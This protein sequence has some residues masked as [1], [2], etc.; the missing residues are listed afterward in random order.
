MRAL[1]IY[2][3]KAYYIAQSTAQGHLSFTKSNLTEIEYN[4]NFTNEN[5]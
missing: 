5:I 2:L 3:L 1:C 4:T